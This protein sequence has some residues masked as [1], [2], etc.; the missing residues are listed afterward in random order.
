MKCL[1][2][3]CGLAFS[4]KTA[5]AR[6]LSKVTGCTYISLDQ[7]NAERGLYGGDGIPDREWE[8]THEIAQQ[9]MLAVM[10]DGQD[11]VLDDTSCFRW[12]RTRYREFARQNGYQAQVV[13]LEIPVAEIRRRVAANAALPQRRAIKPAVFDQHLRTFEQPLVDECA[14]V[15]DNPRAIKKWIDSKG[16][17]TSGLKSADDNQ[18]P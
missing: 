5:F 16:M 4:G 17:Q 15:L 13:Y 18:E 9:R 10:A 14:I 2:L 1:Y 12:L 3:M 7:I 6:E 8:R 11:I